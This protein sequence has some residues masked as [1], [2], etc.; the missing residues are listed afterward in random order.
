[1]H[2]K[3]TV[4]TPSS[5]KLYGFSHDKVREDERLFINR[6]S[7]NYTYKSI[8]PRKAHILQTSCFRSFNLTG[9]NHRKMTIRT[10]IRKNKIFRDKNK[11]KTKLNHAITNQRLLRARITH[12]TDSS[13]DLAR[14]ECPKFYKIF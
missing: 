7:E 12:L 10:N 4:L 1:M 11:P 3:Q 13:L 14:K 6:Y 2:L 9:I 8:G 5:F